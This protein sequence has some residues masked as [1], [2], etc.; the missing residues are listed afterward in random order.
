MATYITTWQGLQDMNLNKSE[1]Y[2]LSN[3]LTEDMAGYETIGGNFT[4][5]GTA[6]AKFTGVF[7]GMGF[8]IR[9]LRING[10]ART[11]ATGMFA[12]LRDANVLEETAIIKT[13]L[14]FVKK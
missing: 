12:Y 13:V 2:Y 10:V 3:D 11:E 8:T 14:A 4:P 1:T 9:G 6:A 5:I 7:N